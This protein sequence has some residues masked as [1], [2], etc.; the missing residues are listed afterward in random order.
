MAPAFAYIHS[1]I[2]S[3]V[4]LNYLKSP[5]DYRMSEIL[6]I[7]SYNFLRFAN[8]SYPKVFSLGMEIYKEELAPGE[9]IEG[10]EDIEQ[11]AVLPPTLPLAFENLKKDG[12]YLKWS[13]ENILVLVQPEAP[14]DLL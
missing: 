4:I 5:T 14:E 2:N 8:H 7:N 13:E 6:K 3:K 10:D 12:V 11:G 9:P 1:F